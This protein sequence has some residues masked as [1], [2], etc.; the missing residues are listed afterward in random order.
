MW[1]LVVLAYLAW[2]HSQKTEVLFLFLLL[3]LL[4]T[5][6]IFVLFLLPMLILI[7]AKVP[8]LA[9]GVVIGTSVVALLY[10]LVGF[11]FLQPMQEASILRSPNLPSI[12]NPITFNL[13]GFG[14]KIWN[15]LGL[16]VTVGVGTWFANKVKTLDYRQ[17]FSAVWI[18][19]YATM[20]TVQQS[21][22]TNYVFIF[23]LPLVLFW[24][25]FNNKREVVLLLAYNLICTIQ[26]SIWWR[27]GQIRYN[28]TTDI[29]ID[30]LHILD[31][32]MQILVVCFT[33]YF[34]FLVY[35][36]AVGLV[37]TP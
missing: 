16:L 12:I 6:I 31:F 27:F 10:Y 17:S 13:L 28:N 30:S 32:T 37:K 4:C 9:F 24:I 3:G 14:S 21:A 15:W 2:Q 5:K 33:I 18:V 26:P 34:I 1:L 25:D 23:L 8:I 29:F 35:K 36:K 20:M 19:I 7:R 22:Y 11:E